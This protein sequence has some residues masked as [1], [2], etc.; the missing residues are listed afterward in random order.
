MGR[1]SKYIALVALTI[2]IIGL[3]I[4]FASYTRTLTISSSA[5][6][7]P[8][9]TFDVI[10]TPTTNGSC[11]TPGTGSS[12][13]PTKSPTTLT[14]TNAV[15]A[16]TGSGA[17]KATNL[18]VDFTAPGQNVVYKFCAYNNSTYTAYLNAVTVGSVSCS[19]ASGSQ[20]T[21]GLVTSACTGISATLNIAGT[22]YT[23]TNNN[24]SSHTLG[25]GTAELVT[26]TISY[27]NG[28]ALA[29]GAFV[30]NIGDFALK[31]DTLEL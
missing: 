27:A 12:V 29:D 9:D 23:S 1:N 21:S 2:A 3:G 10:L 22:N 30:V 13:A 20:A 15:I 8:V 17:P 31:Y 25:A 5:T 18:S 24:I 16:N 7:N 19:V 28:S 14:T 6:V 26:L 4:G 11:T